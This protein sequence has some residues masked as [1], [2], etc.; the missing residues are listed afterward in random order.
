[1]VHKKPVSIASL[2]TVLG[3]AL[4]LSTPAQAR[5]GGSAFVCKESV[6][7]YCM[8][9]AGYCSSGLARCTYTTEPCQ[10]VDAEC[11]S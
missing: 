6:E 5:A 4:L 3:G 1:M 7:E 8:Y 2:L 9:V 11:V 10:I